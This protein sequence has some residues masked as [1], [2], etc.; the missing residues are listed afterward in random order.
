LRHSFT[1]AD[2]PASSSATS[3]MMLGIVPGRIDQ[4]GLAPARLL[5]AGLERPRDRQRVRPPPI[6]A[7]NLLLSRRA[8]EDR[9]VRVDL[10][11]DLPPK[12]GRTSVSC[13]HLLHRVDNFV[14]DRDLSRFFGV[15][16]HSA[17][18]FG[19]RRLN[20]LSQGTVFLA[21]GFSTIEWSGTS[22]VFCRSLIVWI[23]TSMKSSDA[24]EFGAT[25]SAARRDGCS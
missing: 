25:R 2:S 13:W 22:S 7:L 5:A 3:E 19:G 24:S 21:K 10:T 4:L 17:S 6:L 8:A 15:N 23:S 14:D 12:R 16:S 1:S 11:A 20:A 18:P 9:S